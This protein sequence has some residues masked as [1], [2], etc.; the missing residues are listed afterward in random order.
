[1]SFIYKTVDDKDIGTDK[2]RFD[3]KFDDNCT[4]NITKIGELKSGIT[5]KDAPPQCNKYKCNEKRKVLESSR[6]SYN[7]KDLTEC[8]ACIEEKWDP[9]PCQIS[10]DIF[11]SQA[12]NWYNT[13]GPLKDLYTI[14][15]YYI[16]KVSDTQ[17]DMSYVYNARNGSDIGIDKRRFTYSINNH[18]SIKITNMDGYLSG[19]T[20]RDAP[21]QCN[22][23]SC[24][25]R[26]QSLQNSRTSYNTSSLT[27]CNNCPNESW[28]PPPCQISNDI[29]S[30]Q[31][32]NW[33]NS[34]GPFAGSYTITPYYVNKLNDS[35]FDMSY[36]YNARNGSD[37][38]IDK[39]RFSYSIN[40]SNCSINVYNMDSYLSGNTVSDAPRPAPVY[41]PP[42]VY[43]PPA[44]SCNYNACRSVINGYIN[45]FWAYTSSN[46]GE[47]AGCPVVSYPNNV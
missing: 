32:Q 41:V 39:R 7:T 12:Q 17:F 22:T 40:H 26:K 29:L 23:S 33:Y 18:C 11:K 46:F 20:A 3:Y 5:A 19:T 44:N 30:S 6:T 43:I 9:P 15:P 25:N 36:V 21:P 31:A 1:M 13:L 47:C 2:R 24:N 34:S 37:N 4:P 28:N 8:N 45:N 38:G 42:P 27:E 14:T 35:Q 16:N 10:D